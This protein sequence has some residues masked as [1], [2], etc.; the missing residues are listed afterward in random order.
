MN[1]NQRIEMKIFSVYLVL[2]L[3]A[4]FYPAAFVHA[5]ETRT[6]TTT[7][8]TVTTDQPATTG[9]VVTGANDDVSVDFNMKN[10]FDAT[11]DVTGEVI[12]NNAGAVA[13]PATFH[14]KIFHDD[15]LFKEFVTEKESLSPGTTTFTLPEFG[16]PD[17]NA[18]RNFQGRWVIMVYQDDPAKSKEVNFRVEPLAK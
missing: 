9:P 6:T 13:L 16:F 1:S 10:N 14:V 7:V 11:E 12:V 5:E 3:A 8:T 2:G 15:R 17:L 4:C 18:N